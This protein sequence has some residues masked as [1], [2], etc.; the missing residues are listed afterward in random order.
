MGVHPIGHLPPSEA[1][2][3]PTAPWR[4]LD[5]GRAPRGVKKYSSAHTR[6]LSDRHRSRAKVGTGWAVEDRM[7][8]R[9]RQLSE[10]I[11]DCYL[12]AEQARIQ[13]KYSY[14]P[15][16]KKEPSTWSGA[17]SP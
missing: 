4:V 11:A 12:G 3:D 13:A 6:M 14:D 1:I 2:D 17:G 10:E 9:L 16:L 7:M 15:A 5:N 8:L